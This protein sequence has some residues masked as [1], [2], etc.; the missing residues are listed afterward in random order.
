MKLHLLPKRHDWTLTPLKSSHLPQQHLVRT[1]PLMH[2]LHALLTGLP[3]KLLMVISRQYCHPLIPPSSHANPRPNRP[4]LYATTVG[5]VVITHAL[6]KQI[7]N[8]VTNYIL[9]CAMLKDFSQL[10]EPKIASGLMPSTPTT[11]YPI[12][13]CIAPTDSR[14]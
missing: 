14:I 9:D 5:T 2:S 3:T 12:S 13:V 7:P 8:C 11:I 10:P 4:H 1:I 6:G